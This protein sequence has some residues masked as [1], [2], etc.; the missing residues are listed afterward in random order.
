MHEPY[1]A[2]PLGFRGPEVPNK[3]PDTAAVASTC[4]HHEGDFQNTRFDCP[5]AE[6]RAPSADSTGCCNLCAATPANCTHWTFESGTCSMWGGRNCRRVDAAGAISRA[7][8]GRGPPPGP[9]SQPGMH[10]MPVYHQMLWDADLYI[11]KL[12]DALKH[13]S[14]WQSTLL[15]YS[16]DNGGTGSGINYPL[17]G[18]KH[19]NWEA[20]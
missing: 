7:Y 14:M 20:R 11:G 17:R 10:P 18:T 5:S 15:F 4:T 3:G 19:T 12:V 6:A 13:K 2:P 16:A 8:G 9:P 1:D